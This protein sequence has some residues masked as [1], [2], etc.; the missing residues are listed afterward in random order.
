VI[1]SKN[2]PRFAVGAMVSVLLAVSTVSASYGIVLPILPLM[3]QAIDG[4]E[5]NDRGLAPYRPADRRTCARPLL[6]SHLSGES[7]PIDLGDAKY[8]ALT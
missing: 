8:C 4:P 1:G 5:R 6:I 7:Y 2:E 3:L